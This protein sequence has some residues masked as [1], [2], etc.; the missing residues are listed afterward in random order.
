M[1]GMAVDE[2]GVTALELTRQTLA[3]GATVGKG[4]EVCRQMF[5]DARAKMLS[6]ATRTQKQ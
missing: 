5:L 2:M 4:S 3:G 1:Y 6:K